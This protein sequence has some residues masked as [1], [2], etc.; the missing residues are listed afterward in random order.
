MDQNRWIQTFKLN[1]V[2][3]IIIFLKSDFHYVVLAILELNV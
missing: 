1:L 2:I 3:I